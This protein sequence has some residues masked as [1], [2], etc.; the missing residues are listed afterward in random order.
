MVSRTLLQCLTRRPGSLSP[1]SKMLKE[2]NWAVLVCLVPD[3]FS[4]SASCAVGAVE[5]LAGLGTCVALP[6]LARTLQLSW[7]QAGGYGNTSLLLAA[8][9]WQRNGRAG[10]RTELS[11]HMAWHGVSKVSVQWLLAAAS[12]RAGKS[13]EGPGLS[14]RV[15]NLK[16]VGISLRVG[17]FLLPGTGTGARSRGESE[18]HHC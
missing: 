5:K 8:F 3:G 7:P 17:I 13:V 11:L 4:T 2:S 12:R 1:L 15:G 14:R 16:H 9:T 6:P 10:L 18:L